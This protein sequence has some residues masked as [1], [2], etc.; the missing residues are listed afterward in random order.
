MHPDAIIAELATRQN[1]N[2]TR[3][4]LV[5]AGLSRGAIA[6]RVRSGR[7]HRHYHAVY[8]VGHTAEPRFAREHGAVLA[9]GADAFLSDRAAAEVFEM[10]ERVP[11]RDID[12]S[13]RSRSSRSRPG[14][15]I[16]R[17]PALD[18]CDTGFSHG[19]PITSPARTL[20]DFAVEAQLRELER[21]FHEALVQN[22][23]T[24]TALGELIARTPG[25]HGMPLIATLL[26]DYVGPTLTRSDGEERM[27]ALAR[28]ARF[29]RPEVNAVIHGY[30]VDFLWRAQQVVV[31][32]DSGRWHGNPAALERDHR[33][34]ADLRR[35]EYEVLRYTW[36]QIV[37]DR[38]AVVA[39][40][41]RAI[42]GPRR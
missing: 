18:R 42:G 3:G 7:L 39:E 6:H 15:R 25:H 9:C 36:K 34:N 24:R 41:A 17:R 32:V 19:I 5:H 29:P 35:R 11:G 13:I 12:V 2:V 16:H 38:D 8:L 40:L 14:I 4:Q 21:A 33:K 31:E 22:L 27:L 28:S 10:V 20:L 26:D 30:E 37:H 1:G 23:V